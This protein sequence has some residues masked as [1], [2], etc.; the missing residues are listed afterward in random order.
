MQ[1]RRRRRF[2]NRTVIARTA[3]AQGASQSHVR[4]VNSNGLASGR[5]GNTPV[6]SPANRPANGAMN[7]RTGTPNAPAHDTPAMNGRP[8]TTPNTSAVSPRQR[9]LSQKPAALGNAQL[10]ANVQ[11]HDG[12]HYV[13]AR[14]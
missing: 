4:T 1:P 2:R 10:S 14:G 6:N 8:A 5:I 3:P 12:Q 9:E 13:A 7:Q 11:R